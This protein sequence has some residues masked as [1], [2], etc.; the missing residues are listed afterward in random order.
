[1]AGL[2]AAPAHQFD[3]MVLCYF[4]EAIDCTAEWF[5]IGVFLE[6][7]SMLFY[8]FVAIAVFADAKRIS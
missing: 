8:H 4:Y 5:S 7:H 6:P 3:V 2:W 1:M